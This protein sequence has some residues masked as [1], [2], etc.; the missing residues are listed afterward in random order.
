MRE[1]EW[2]IVSCKLWERIS[3]SL[4]SITV[5]SWQSFYTHHIFQLSHYFHHFSSS[6]QCHG[7]FR[8]ENSSLPTGKKGRL[9]WRLYVLYL[10]TS[11]LLLNIITNKINI[12][13]IQVS[14]ILSSPLR[15]VW[16]DSELC[17]S[18]K[19]FKFHIEFT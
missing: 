2:R 19:L 8:S 5:N 4:R 16:Y 14:E 18:K 15:T 9:E 13:L 17:W 12:I 3:S 6:F 7:N 1:K 10:L 11:L